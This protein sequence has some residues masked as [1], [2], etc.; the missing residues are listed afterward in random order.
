MI[1]QCMTPQIRDHSDGN[2]NFRAEGIRRIAD[3][4]GAYCKMSGLVSGAGERWSVDDLKPY[5]GHVLDVFGCDRIMWGS[6]WP[7][8]RL[9]TECSGWFEA[10]DRLTGG[11]PAS[12]R[13]QIFGGN[14]ARF[15]RLDL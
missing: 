3:E 14:A 7:V 11:L 5:A 4:T 10:A 2:F 8:C 1:V 13:P 9:S 12:E 15:C 6:D